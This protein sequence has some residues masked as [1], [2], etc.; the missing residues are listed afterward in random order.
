[1]LKKSK[2]AARFYEWQTDA[3]ATAANNAQL[4]GDDVASFA[5]VVPTV[6]WGNQ[7]QIST[8]SIIVSRTENIVDKAGRD[9]ELDY[10][11]VKRTKEIKRDVEFALIQN[12]TLNSGA[13]VTARQT[14]GLAG[15]IRQGSV[16]AATG[17]FPIPASNTAPVAGTLR[18]LT[19]TLVKNA[20]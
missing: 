20:M 1:M 12:T 9:K 17:A 7:C 8:K 2:C 16:G 14:R 19:E 13:T 6:R 5:A 3:L 10:Q 11:T 15:W 4:E 18:P